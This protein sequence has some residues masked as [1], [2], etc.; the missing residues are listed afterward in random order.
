[1]WYN[2]N[3]Y[4]ISSRKL[5]GLQIMTCVIIVF[6]IL[7]V[8]ISSF[9]IVYS[10]TYVKGMS[11]Y[12]T[13]NS[14]QSNQ[15]D[16]IYINRFN[17]GVKGDI[18]VL[19]LRKNNNFGNYT[20]KRLIA[21]EGDIVNIVFDG[22]QYNLI[23]NEQIIYSKPNSALGYNT[24]SSFETYVK[25]HINETSRISK[26]ADEEVKGVIVQK[27]EIFVLG[28][29]WNL[30]KDSSLVGPISKKSVVGRVDIVV[31]PSQN[32]LLTILKRIF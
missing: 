14:P 20:I 1:M 13:L 19:D 11:M 23:V 12:P 17:K 6:A 27:G 2:I 5:L 29:N 7:S 8:I 31:K 24:Y 25:N 15:R 21:S 9:F 4:E 28:D 30:S 26:N 10:R 16:V 18:I 32:E 3:M 22:N